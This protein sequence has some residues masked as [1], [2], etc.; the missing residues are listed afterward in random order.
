MDLARALLPHALAFALAFARVGGFVTVSPFPGPHVAT[1][2]RVGLTVVLA[3]VAVSIAPPPPASLGL[4]LKLVGLTAS[5]LGVGIIFGVAFRFVL[6]AGEMLAQTVAQSTGLA[7]PSV[8]NPTLEAQDTALGQAITLA[9]LA[10][11]LALGAHRVALG[12][13]LESFRA[14]PLG[15]A[16]AHHA[17]THTF[18]DLAAQALAVGLRLSLPVVAASLAAQVAL[19]MIARAAPSL[20]I[21]SVGLTVLLGGGLL[22]FSASL[23]DVQVGLGEHVATLGVRLEQV[24]ADITR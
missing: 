11:A 17:A 8:F 18:V 16:V 7:M 1:T 12:W 4:D 13:L 14:I 5:E 6:A 24:T 20:Q 19:A 15:A 2:A 9:A 10:I 23:G 3:F 21:F 22:V